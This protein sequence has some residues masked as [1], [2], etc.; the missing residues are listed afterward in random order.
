MEKAESEKIPSIFK[1]SNLCNILPYFGYL[2]EWKFILELM[3]IKTRQI[4]SENKE[5][6]IQ[7]GKKYKKMK[8]Y[9]D[10]SWNIPKKNAEL[11]IFYTELLYP[12]IMG[13]LSLEERNLLKFNNVLI[14][15]YNQLDKSKAILIDKTWYFN[16]TIA[17]L[18][19]NEVEMVIPSTLWTSTTSSIQKFTLQ[20]GSNLW[21]L[22]ESLREGMI[23][24][25]RDEDDELEATTVTQN[26]EWS[27]QF[28]DILIHED[29]E[30]LKKWLSWPIENWVWKP[31][32]LSY[33]SGNY[34]YYE[35][36]TRE[37]VD[38]IISLSLLKNIRQFNISNTVKDF[39]SVENLI[40]ISKTF[41]LM[42]IRFNFS[43]ICNA[44]Y[45]SVRANLQINSKE[46]VW[47][48]KG[49]VWVF[50]SY[51]SSPIHYFCEISDFKTTKCN[52]IIELK[53][54]RFD[55][56][57]V[58]PKSNYQ[59]DNRKKL[60]ID[61]L[62]KK[63]VSNNNAFLIADVGTF[64]LKSRLDN[65]N[66]YNDIF[67]YCKSIAIEI[68][69]S[70][71]KVKKEVEEI[72]RLPKQYK[73][74]FIFRRPSKFIESKVFYL[75]EYQLKNA[76]IYAGNYK[77]KIDKT[78]SSNS[79]KISNKIFTLFDM[80]KNKSYTVNINQLKEMLLECWQI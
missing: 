14:P 58:I 74:E 31:T 57:D 38:K 61:K 6:F 75:L 63:T 52:S 55:W 60:M 47:V 33:N 13:L 19:L 3:C 25:K 50:E 34:S 36:I 46:I 80:R 71:S 35:I 45:N 20:E 73:Y 76:E 11:F 22:I 18:T 28:W 49:K 39:E 53:I 40:S 43:Y 16:Q 5:A 77:I 2:H 4:W 65:V 62:I 9:I 37:S 26:Q 41:P 15:L 68:N 44:F 7:W 21:G 69:P 32:I 79:K 59:L 66:K 54:V 72:E 10:G 67:K 78:I 17:I 24:I 12:S 27:I 29:Y 64:T 1:F 42:K 48:C 8:I 70:K 23:I 30:C 56:K 51:D